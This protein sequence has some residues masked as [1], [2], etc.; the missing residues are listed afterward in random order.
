MSTTAIPSRKHLTRRAVMALVLGASLLAGCNRSTDAPRGPAD[1][2]TFRPRTPDRKAECRLLHLRTDTTASGVAV[3]VEL[4]LSVVEF[5]PSIC[6][7]ALTRC[8]EAFSPVNA[9]LRI[10][11]CVASDL[12]CPEGAAETLWDRS[13]ITS[14]CPEVP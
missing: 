6:C 13:L 9:L 1:S 4:N 7:L 8:K 11:L 10:S 2:S 3:C 5:P 12:G 14:S